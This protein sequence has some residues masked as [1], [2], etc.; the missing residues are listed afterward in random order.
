MF[1]KKIST[2]NFNNKQSS[3]TNAVQEGS[4]SSLLFFVYTQ[5]TS[6][7][8]NLCNKDNYLAKTE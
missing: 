2:P 4:T 1:F 5:K 3:K 7:S 8:S 6:S